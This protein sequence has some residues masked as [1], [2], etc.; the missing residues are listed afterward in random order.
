MPQ[1]SRQAILDAVHQLPPKE[2]AAIAQEIMRA[3]TQ[4][5]RRELPPAPQ[6]GSAASLR[7]I[8]RTDT[9]IDEQQLLDESRDERFG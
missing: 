5:T 7:G 4:N 8:A 3:L 2:Q 6:G 9:P 1:L